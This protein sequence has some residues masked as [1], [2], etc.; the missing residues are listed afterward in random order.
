MMKPGDLVEL[1]FQAR[2]SRVTDDELIF[3]IL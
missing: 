1:R 2:L 3:Q